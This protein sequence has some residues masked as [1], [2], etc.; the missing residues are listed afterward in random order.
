MGTA[1]KKG[2]CRLAPGNSPP[3][4]SSKAEC[5]RRGGNYFLI[6]SDLYPNC[7]DD[8]LHH[9]D[10]FLLEREDILKRCDTFPSLS[11]NNL[12]VF[13][14]LLHPPNKY[15][16]GLDNYRRGLEKF[17]KGS[18]TFPSLSDNYR[19]LSDNFLRQ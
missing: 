18:E 3:P 13:D 6:S 11:D 19:S 1:N 14:N 7:S 12:K 2:D 9:P 5:G 8:N 10:K 4:A 17:Q 15:R 16:K